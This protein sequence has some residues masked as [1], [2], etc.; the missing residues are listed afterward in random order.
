MTDLYFLPIVT[1]FFL[2]FSKYFL[3]L[4]SIF[5]MYFYNRKF[6]IPVLLLSFTV[7]LT[8]ILKYFFAIP[9]PAEL[10]ERLGK[11]GYIFPS[12]HM[13]ATFVFYGCVFFSL[14]NTVLR[15]FLVMII[16]GVGFSLIF[17]KYH[18][19]N[20]IIGACFF[21]S[22]TIF[23]YKF[24]LNQLVRYHIDST[25]YKIFP[26]SILSILLFFIAHNIL[27]TNL[28]MLLSV[29]FNVATLVFTLYFKFKKKS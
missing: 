4:L 13:Q 9:Y 22:C 21:G 15:G 20:D 6:L 1:S 25:I 27:Y 7:V 16:I 12:G 8:P 24:Y 17:N 23:F 3:L 2:L 28:S 29:F 11:T 14:K 10:S 18:N 26:V 19:F 5:G